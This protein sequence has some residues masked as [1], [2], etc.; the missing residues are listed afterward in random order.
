[1]KLQVNPYAPGQAKD[2]YQDDILNF[3]DSDRESLISYMQSAAALQ[4]FQGTDHE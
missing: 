4:V 2:D 1:M 3:K